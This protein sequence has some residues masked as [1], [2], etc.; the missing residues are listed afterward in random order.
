MRKSQVDHVLRAAREHSGEE[1][2]IIIGSQSLHGKHPDVVDAILV[3]R[4][5][6]LFIPHKERLTELLNGVGEGSRFHETFGYYADPVGENTA[7]LPKGWKGRLVNL[8]PGDT[9]GAKG[10]CL[11]PHDLAISKYIAGREKDRIFTAALAR[12]GLLDRE[13]L[14]KR[15]AQT[16]VDETRRAAAKAAIER[17]FKPLAGSAVPAPAGR[18][19]K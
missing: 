2:F 19:R 1:R 18:S 10:L 17:D 13:L 3:S 7:I 9:N 14:H 5:V 6:D 4:E 16:Q 8:P 11:D 15:L 12:R